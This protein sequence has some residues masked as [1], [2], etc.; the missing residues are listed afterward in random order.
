MLASSRKRAGAMKAGARFAILLGT[1]PLVLLAA[2]VSIPAQL[3]ASPGT[4]D[5]TCAGLVQAEGGI[6]T[7]TE[8]HVGA[9]EQVRRDAIVDANTDCL[10]VLMAV[11]AIYTHTNGWVQS[12][13]E[14]LKMLESG[15]VDYKS[16][17]VSHEKVLLHGTSAVIT[18]SQVMALVVRGKPVTS[19]SVY[20]VVW[21]HEDGAWRFLAYQSTTL[22][23]EASR[24]AAN[25]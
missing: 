17:D 16:I 1:V 7:A 8:A 14:F 11:D 21:S 2:T 10:R 5:N 18:G 25:E 6:G 19:V 22:A 20:T 24:D 4:A 12:T 3:H 15:D 9:L 23:T 13:G